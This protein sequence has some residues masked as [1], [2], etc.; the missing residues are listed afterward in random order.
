MTRAE[1]SWAPSARG[2]NSASAAATAGMPAPRRGLACE[3]RHVRDRSGWQRPV[4]ESR[5]AL[6][7]AEPGAAKL[8][9]RLGGLVGFTHRFDHAVDIVARLD[10]A[11]IGRLFDLLDRIPVSQLESLADHRHDAPR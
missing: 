7:A 9:E 11:D 1:W 8:R 5:R 6:P 4:Q 2:P 10:S 3:V